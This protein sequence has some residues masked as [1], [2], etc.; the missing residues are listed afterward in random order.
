MTSL[1]H[2]TQLGI[3]RRNA[4]GPTSIWI[5]LQMLNKACRTP[6]QLSA[7]VDR[8][9][10]GTTSAD[11]ER[12]AKLCG[13]RL[14][15]HFSRSPDINIFPAIPLHLYGWSSNLTT[16]RYPD[17]REFKGW[18]WSVVNGIDKTTR[19]V[20]YYDTLRIR[21][22]EG[23]LQMPYEQWINNCYKPYRSSYVYIT[24]TEDKGPTL[25]QFVLPRTTR[26]V[27]VLGD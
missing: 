23:G 17:G 12:A 20:S 1:I 3:K 26:N 15:T 4:C 11:L 22:P 2:A 8:E 18:H 7:A 24:L 5:V 10:D 6:A 9:Q 19:T 16:Y 21:V 13:V 25:R 14:T 27:G